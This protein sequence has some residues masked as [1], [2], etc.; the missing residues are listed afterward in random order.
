MATDTGARHAQGRSQETLTAANQ[1][2]GTKAVDQ[3]EPREWR[4]HV[5]K[6]ARHQE[7]QRR[8]S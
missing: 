2:D 5:A 6:D 3:T 4:V 1:N 7:I 8:P